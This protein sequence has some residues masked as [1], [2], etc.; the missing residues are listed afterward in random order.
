MLESWCVRSR[1]I[2]TFWAQKFATKRVAFV[3]FLSVN[4]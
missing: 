3:A 2:S 4:F 1:G